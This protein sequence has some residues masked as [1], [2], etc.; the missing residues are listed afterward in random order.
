[1]VA[2]R[3]LSDPAFRE[4]YARRT[5]GRIKNCEVE[6]VS[7]PLGDRILKINTVISMDGF[8]ACLSGNSSYGKVVIL[9]GNVPFVANYAVERY[10]KRLRMLSDKLA[11][12]PDYAIDAAQEKI[13]PQE[14]MALYDIYLKKLRDTVYSRRPNTPLEALEKGWETFAGLE[15]ARQAEVLLNIH[16][17][18][19][20]VAGGTD[21][22]AI[23]GVK[24]AAAS[25]K[26]ST[27]SNWLKGCRDVRI[28]DQSATGLWETRSQNLLELL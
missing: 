3:Y 19:G 24:K 11:Q 14:N 26:S 22:S 15:L 21:L 25:T 23:G 8:R 9:S 16:A 28:I 20:R 10:L 4:D 12:K 1:M 13:S 5:I 27:L 18:F 6:R 7:F 2:D 17:V